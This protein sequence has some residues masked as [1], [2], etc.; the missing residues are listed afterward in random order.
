VIGALKQLMIVRIINAYISHRQDDK[1]TNMS[2]R[3]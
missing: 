2:V 3:R 1:A